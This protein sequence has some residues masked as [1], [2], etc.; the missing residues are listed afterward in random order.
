[1]V[2]IS[3]IIRHVSWYISHCKPHCH[4]VD[5]QKWIKMPTSHSF[6]F[7]FYAHRF[8]RCNRTHTY[9]IYLVQSKNWDGGLQ[10]R[11][12]VIDAIAQIFPGSDV[13]SHS[14]NAYPLR[15]KVHAKINGGE[16]GQAEK[17]K[18]W[19]G[20]QKRLFKKHLEMRAECVEEIKEALEK[21]RSDVKM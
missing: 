9:L 11:Q 1:M 20:D 6:V 2:A 10:E 21:L 15:L 14:K 4:I 13:E 7:L 18:V 17:I 8:L 3:F 16:E 5:M 19:D 12:T